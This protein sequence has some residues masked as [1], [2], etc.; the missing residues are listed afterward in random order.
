MSYNK[1]FMKVL[2]NFIIIKFQSHF[3]IVAAQNLIKNY[4]PETL[5]NFICELTTKD[6]GI[7]FLSEWTIQTFLC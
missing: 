3:I 2:I 4:N 1:Y 5:K 6:F 7:F